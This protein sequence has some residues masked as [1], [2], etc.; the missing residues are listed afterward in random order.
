MK[1]K[2]TGNQIKK[3]IAQKSPLKKCTIQNVVISKYKYPFY[4]GHPNTETFLI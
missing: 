1:R 3:Y 4:L 2:D